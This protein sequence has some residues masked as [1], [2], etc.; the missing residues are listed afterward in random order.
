MST[1]GK[2]GETKSSVNQTEFG[3]SVPVDCENRYIYTPGVVLPLAFNRL[4]YISSGQRK[5]KRA[6]PDSLGGKE[7]GRRVND[8]RYSVVKLTV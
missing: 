5:L 2:L 1:V 3:E 8:R 6:W 4:R 7:L